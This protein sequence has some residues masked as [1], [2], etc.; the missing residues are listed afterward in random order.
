MTDGP[1]HRPHTEADDEWIM[2]GDNLAAPS[3]TC[4]LLTLLARARAITPEGVDR[5]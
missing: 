1:L 3:C 4:G 5:P 2:Q